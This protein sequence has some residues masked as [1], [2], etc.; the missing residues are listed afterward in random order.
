V[1]V[2]QYPYHFVTVRGPVAMAEDVDDLLAWATKIAE[3]YVP[4][5]RAA[6]YGRRNAV[7]GE[8]VCRL[9]IERLIGIADVAH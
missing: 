2:D 8:M 4:E 1:D 3:R 7:A 6:D 5:G 9:P